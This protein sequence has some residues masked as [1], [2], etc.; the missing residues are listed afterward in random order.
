MNQLMTS[1]KI[2]SSYLVNAETLS[3]EKVKVDVTPHGSWKLR[4]NSAVTGTCDVVPGEPWKMLDSKGATF[5]TLTLAQPHVH[6]MHRVE[7]RS[8]GSGPRVGDRVRYVFIDDK[9]QKSDLQIARAECPEYAQAKGLRPDAVY[10]YEHSVR[11]PLNAVLSLF[12]KERGCDSELGWNLALI[13][14]KNKA[15]GQSALSAF[16]FG[17]ANPVKK[18]SKVSRQ[19]AKKRKIVHVTKPA[20][21]NASG[22][23]MLF[24]SK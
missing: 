13:T 19:S 12:A 16:G 15:E 10:Y 4:D 11:P 8:R 14:A 21:K 22:I 1:K 6:V 23:A 9:K 2:S 3:G 7:A 5:G 20:T 17:A 24:K 18:P